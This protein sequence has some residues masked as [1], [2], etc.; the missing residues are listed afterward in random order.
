[1]LAV[2]NSYSTD[3]VTG[4]YDALIGLTL[5]GDGKNNFKNIPAKK[6]GFFVDGDGK[7]IA[8]MESSTGGSIIWATQNSDSIKLF[9]LYKEAQ[10]TTIHP[11]ASELFATLT[12]KNGKRRKIELNY[13]SAYLSQSSRCIHITPESDT[14]KFYNRS[15][16]VTRTFR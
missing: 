15:G 3:V 8:Q 7:G 14:L 16:K 11:M 10:H 2:G 13:G 1:M 9:K 5:L 4:R 12:M 6:S